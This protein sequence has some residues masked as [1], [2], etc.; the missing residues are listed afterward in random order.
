MTQSIRGIASQFWVIKVPTDSGAPSPSTTNCCVI[1]DKLGKIILVDP[2]DDCEEARYALA[3][4]FKDL[5]LRFSQIELII[6]SHLH[7][8]HMGIAAH[9]QE[10]S[11]ARFAIHATEHK[12]IV[13]GVLSVM[14][15]EEQLT[16]WG[17]P[18]E[19]WA[20]L[21]DLPRLPR[22]VT[23]PRWDVLLSDKQSVSSPGRHLEITH[24]PGHTAGHIAILEKESGVLMTGDLILAEQN[25][26]IG[27]GGQLTNPLKRYRE[28]LK[29]VCSIE[30]QTS[31]PGHGKPL[32][33]LRER[34]REVLEHHDHRSRQISAV[35]E[36]DPRARVWDVYQQLTWS[37][38]PSSFTGTELRLALHHV[39]IHIQHIK[40]VT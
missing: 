7:R 17:V 40:E 16:V 36:H 37:R 32:D 31:I 19:R 29:L 33:D 26:G 27:L 11:D 8:D 6:A 12:A 21:Q 25:P 4:G 35:I 30:H 24:V 14:M 28:S 10:V 1:L 9:I 13:S 39:D 20:E 2:G 38:D 22:E 5:G 34:S 15:T 23:H 18:L 3:A